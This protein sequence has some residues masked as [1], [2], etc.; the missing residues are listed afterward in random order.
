MTRIPLNR[1]IT[2]EKRFQKETIWN[3]TIIIS[4]EVDEMPHAHIKFI[5]HGVITLSSKT[6]AVGR[7]TTEV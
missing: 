2:E 3:K 6:P 4:K 7:F 5:V 1:K